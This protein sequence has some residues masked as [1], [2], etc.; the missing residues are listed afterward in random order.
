MVVL[1]GMQRRAGVA[2]I[3]AR[4]ELGSVALAAS[5]ARPAWTSHV[6]ESC[7][8]SSCKGSHGVVLVV[9]RRRVKAEMYVFRYVWLC[10]IH[11]LER[12]VQYTSAINDRSGR[13]KA[14]RLV[15]VTQINAH[16]GEDLDRE[17]LQCSCSTGSSE[18]SMSSRSESGRQCVR[19]R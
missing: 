16:H 15:G 17:K 2:R 12:A 3:V 1:A 10:R 14:V 8:W 9:Q 4:M 19:L 11:Q 18:K 7:Q 5:A 6:H 13:H